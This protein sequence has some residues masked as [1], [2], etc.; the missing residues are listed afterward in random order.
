MGR[1]H[2]RDTESTEKRIRELATDEHR[3]TQMKKKESNE[4]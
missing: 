3:S 4:R 1:T 2:H